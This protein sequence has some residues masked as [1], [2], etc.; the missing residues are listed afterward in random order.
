MSLRPAN[1]AGRWASVEASAKLSD[2]PRPGRD[3]GTVLPL[4]S[5]PREGPGKEAAD[6]GH[7]PRRVAGRTTLL[8]ARPA[9][10]PGTRAGRPTVPRPSYRIGA[11]R[12]STAL[13]ELYLH[14]RFVARRQV[15]K[16]FGAGFHLYAPDGHLIAYSKQKAFRLKEDIRVFADEAMTHEVLW[17][18]ADRIVDWSAAYQVRD[19]QTGEHY[20]TLRRKGW[21]SMFR[22]SWEVLDAEGT[23][24]GRVI[25]DSGWMALVRRTV[26]LASL[27]F[28]QKFRIE[29]G[30]AVIGTMKQNFNPFVHKFFVDLSG[31][32][33]GLLPRPLAVATVVLLLAIEGRQGGGG[34]NFGG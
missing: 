6:D 22:D 2:R 3:V 24:R 18:Q 13:P 25:E 17:I 21:K 31:D 14:D 11:D 1:G 12:M 9:I 20:G 33:D 27:F 8:A 30:D 23:V 7:G 26:D 10:P 5:G 16:I 32:T 28:P 34:I 15:M 19:S 4:A 29:V